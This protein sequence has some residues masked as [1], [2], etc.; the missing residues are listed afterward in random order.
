MSQ[1]AS[2]F[3]SGGDR[4][5][6]ESDQLGQD[7][8]GLGWGSDEYFLNKINFTD[9]NHLWFLFSSAASTSTIMTLLCSLEHCE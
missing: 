8:N 7:G 1:N 4:L 9:L 2:I 3:A 5:G 6:M